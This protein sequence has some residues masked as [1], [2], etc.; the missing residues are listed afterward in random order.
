VSERAAW[1]ALS[2]VPGLGPSRFRRL[3]DLYGSP[4]CAL[5]AGAAAIA[6]ET[7]L[8]QSA[9]SQL[10]DV[11]GRLEQVQQ[12][13]AS[14][15]EE[16]V[17]ALTW[18]DEAYPA[19]LL[20]T[21]SPPPVLWWTSQRCSTQPE[22]AAAV[23]GSRE[24]PEEALVEACRI[25][26]ALA[27]AAVSVVS[28]LAA[29]VDAAAHEAAL[30]CGGPTIGVC[31]CGIVTA[32]TRGRGGLAARVAEDGALC[33]ELVPTA[34][35]SPKMLFARNRIIAGLAD[36]VIVVE[37]RAEGGAVHTANCARQEG[38]PVLVVDWPG[39]DSAGGNRQL[40]RAGATPLLPGADPLSAFAEAIGD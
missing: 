31:G 32:L 22:A 33:S 29:G 35:L 30:G 4:L 1:I 16:G 23:V 36:A 15:D 6:R 37:A 2:A 40:L 24:V 13:L 21:S 18:H 11:A 8:S 26:Q 28:G 12:E 25:G 9:L 34:P 39:R 38:R 27:E 5:D 14:L 3:L 17:Q 19:R 7:D 20:A 10:E